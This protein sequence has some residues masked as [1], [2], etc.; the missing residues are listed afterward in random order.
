MSRRCPP[1]GKDPPLTK[2]FVTTAA[3]RSTDRR[4][5]RSASA[6]RGVLLEL[7]WQWNHHQRHRL[8]TVAQ[9]RRTREL[10]E[11]RLAPA[12]AALSEEARVRDEYHDTQA[13]TIKAGLQL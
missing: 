10:M 1:L 4:R 9:L 11:Q 6:L 8:L 2:S 12:H 7:E 5:G 3:S 13:R